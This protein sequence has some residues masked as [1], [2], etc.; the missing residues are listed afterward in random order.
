MQSLKR[1]DPPERTTGSVTPLVP[2]QDAGRNASTASSSKGGDAQ[3]D[4]PGICPGMEVWKQRFEYADQLREVG[5]FV[6]ARSLLESALDDCSKDVR[7][8]AADVL[9]DLPFKPPPACPDRS[10]WQERFLYADDLKSRD[11]IED[12]RAVLSPMLDACNEGVRKDAL[13]KLIALPSPPLQ[14]TAARPKPETWDQRLAYGRWL[15]KSGDITNAR[16]ILLPALA[17]CDLD[18]REQAFEILRYTSPRKPSLWK[19]FFE[20]ATSAFSDGGDIVLKGLVGALLTILTYFIVVAIRNIWNR[21]R[22]ATNALE[23][24]GDGFSGSQFID[25]IADNYF[26]LR[27]LDLLQQE[28]AELLRVGGA[29]R[30]IAVVAPRVLLGM[31]SRAVDPIGD[32]AE[33]I[34]GETAGKVAAVFLKLIRQPCYICSGSAMLGARRSYV[35]VRLERRGEIIARWDCTSTPARLIPDLQTCALYMLQTTADDIAKPDRR[36]W[37]VW[38]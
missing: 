35:V 3:P 20:H 4:P 21:T 1:L 25:I 7:H 18:V 9:K 30:N 32:A 22:L 15:E 8:R 10:I 26:Q 6:G 36:W 37:L 27:E 19:R 2:G 14:T 11:M 17:D 5:E 38:R 13:A 33:A 31:T 24:S 12:S 29:A 34:S 16:T 28:N 23:V